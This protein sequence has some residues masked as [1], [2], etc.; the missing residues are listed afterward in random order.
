MSRASEFDRHAETYDDDLNR[1]L[2]VSGENKE[3]FARQRVR[4]LKDCLNRLALRPRAVLDYGCGSG[5]TACW[6]RELLQVDSILGVDVSVRSLERAR[7]RYASSHC[8]FLTFAEYQ[9]D[10]S[11]DLVYCNGVFHHIPPPQHDSAIAYIHRS[12]RPGGIF[13]LWENNPWN[14]GA[15]YVMSRC[16]F[17]RKAVTITPPRAAKLLAQGGFEILSLD[18]QFFFP[19]SLSYF[20]FL[21]SRLSRFPVGAQYQVLG[22]KPGA[23]R[24][25][26]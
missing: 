14:P 11:I 6:L 17:D 5:D 26:G 23:D 3:Y 7:A 12:L 10:E 22:R 4:W 15:R 1:A 9:P 20:R 19:R 8:R 24:G 25:A 21:E 13:A 18:Y 2:S 16:P